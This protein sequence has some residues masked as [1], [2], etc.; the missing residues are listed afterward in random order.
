MTPD[1]PESYYLDNVLTLF[2]QVESLYTDILEPQQLGFLQTFAALSQDAKKLYIRLL[3]R[4]HLCFR[5]NKLHYAEIGSIDDAIGELEQAGCLRVNAELD[6]ATLLSLFNKAELLAIIDQPAALKKLKRAEL[7]DYLLN[8][9]E[10]QASLKAQHDWLLLQHQDDYQLCQMLF[11]GNLRQSMTDFV[12]RDLGLNQYE[13]YPIDPEHRAY[14]SQLEIQQHWLLQQLE[15]LLELE[16]PEDEA[17]LLE[18]FALIPDD[19][20]SDAPA[21]HKSERLRY[22]IARQMERCGYLATALTLYQA[23]LLPPGRERSARIHAQLDRPQQALDLCLSII[24]EP[25]DDSEVQFAC[26]FGARLIKRHS[27]DTEALIEAHRISHQP[28]VLLLQLA[29]QDSVEIAVAE[30]YDAQDGHETCYFLE[31]SL[32]N[33][34]LGLL[35][36]DVIFAPL[37]GAFF[38]PFQYRPA[39]LYAHDFFDRRAGL[40][41]DAWAG[42]D[43]NKAI[44]E[45]ALD[46][47]QRKFGL[48]NPLVN[49]QA[50]SPAIIEL[51]LERI[52]H[53]H[54]MAIFKRQLA[55]LGSN[56]SGFPDLL[57]FPDAGGY[58]LIEV[59]GPGDSLQKNQQRWMQYFQ[60]QGIPHRLAKVTWQP[61]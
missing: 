6:G 31:N 19:I 44:R 10:L 50:L 16:M 47:W 56:C 14:R 59:K 29:Q 61:A 45:R 22:Q 42:I 24:K 48:M 55:D 15:T 11:F 12:L 20:A 28:E 39:D 13:A 5:Q 60:Q 23:C 8:Q 17:S 30:Y 57:H 46:C 4:N 36:W 27:L 9:P 40:L 21:W 26:Q 1:L 32:F 52:D 49:W 51:A 33:G 34:L 7:D 37:P 38:N 35:L 53:A 41:E 18:Y 2:S 58:C 43:S 3:N 54:L 25:I